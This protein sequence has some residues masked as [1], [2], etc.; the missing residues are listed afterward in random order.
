MSFEY[1]MKICCCPNPRYLLQHH[2]NIVHTYIH[3]KS[4]AA[5]RER[6]TQY[7]NNNKSE[8]LRTHKSFGS[9]L[10]SPPTKGSQIRLPQQYYSLLRILTHLL[11]FSQIFIAMLYTFYFQSSDLNKVTLDSAFFPQIRVVPKTRLKK[12]NGFSLTY[13]GVIMY[14]YNCLFSKCLHTHYILLC[15][16]K[17]S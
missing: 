16:L 9:T 7:D 3:T 1:E 4:R 8:L 15:L 17:R 14:M 6:E 13:L 12:L 5:Q 10:S 2:Y 11:S